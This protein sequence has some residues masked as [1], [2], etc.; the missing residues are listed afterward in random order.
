MSVNH[1]VGQDGRQSENRSA[2]VRTLALVASAALLA[3][4]LSFLV[5]DAR[6]ATSDQVGIVTV[7]PAKPNR[8]NTFRDRLVVGLKARLKSELAFIDRVVMA[9]NTGRIPARLV[10]QT[11]FWARNRA[12]AN[13]YRSRRP[14][15][16]FQPAMKARAKKLR[17]V[18]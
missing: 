8:P 4:G 1:A 13:W 10:D 18:L 5:I 16:Y 7:T 2:M 6:G 3:G 15:I 11:Y 17:V 12:S 9:V 14:I